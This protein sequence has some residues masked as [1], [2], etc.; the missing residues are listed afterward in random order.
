MYNTGMGYTDP[1]ATALVVGGALRHRRER[2]NFDQ[3]LELEQPKHQVESAMQLH[4]CE[5][6]LYLA[7]EPAKD[8]GKKRFTGGEFRL[9]GKSSGDVELSSLTGEF[10][11]ALALSVTGGPIGRRKRTRAAIVEAKKKCEAIGEQHGIE[12]HV[13]L[14]DQ[15]VKEIRPIAGVVW[16]SAKLAPAAKAAPGAKRVRFESDLAPPATTPEVANSGTPEGET[17]EC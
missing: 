5:Q 17:A 16:G 10:R 3:A 15:T 1:V 11:E 2:K 6:G 9:S 13:I 8:I 14:C 7:V 12:V 4:S